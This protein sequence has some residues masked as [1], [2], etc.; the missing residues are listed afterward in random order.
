M[1]NQTTDL[2]ELAARFVNSTASHIF[3]TGKVE[4]MKCGEG[5]GITIKIL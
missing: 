3:L 1:P 2:L 4:E 5:F